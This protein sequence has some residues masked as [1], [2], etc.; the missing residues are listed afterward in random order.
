MRK[1]LRLPP[2]WKRIPTSKASVYA[3]G[4]CRDCGGTLLVDWSEVD[5]NGEAKIW[6]MDC[7]A[8]FR[9]RDY[10]YGLCRNCGANITESNGYC[11]AC[12]IQWHCKGCHTYV[13]DGSG[14]CEQCAERGFCAN[15]GS[16]LTP[17]GYCPNHCEDRCEKC[18]SFFCQGNCN[19]DSRAEYEENLK[20]NSDK[21]NPGAEEQGSKEESEENKSDV[22]DWI[23]PFPDE[24]QR[25]EECNGPL[26]ENGNCS[27]C[28]VEPEGLSWKEVREWL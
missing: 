17:E 8:E 26:D 13:E 7:G 2:W 25:C 9:Q 24:P 20:E 22:G 21:E 3:E 14:V 6:C 23:A 5:E 16:L 28:C 19:K 10:D 18:G 15:C 4:R 11:E 12:G 1:F 27:N